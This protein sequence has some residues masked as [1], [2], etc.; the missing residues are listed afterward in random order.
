MED[1]IYLS[2]TPLRMVLINF[3]K[4]KQVLIMLELYKACLPLDHTQKCMVCATISK[5]LSCHVTTFT[6]RQRKFM[7]HNIL[8]LNYEAAKKMQLLYQYEWLV[9]NVVC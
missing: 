4:R 1:E 5:K 7:R 3:V 2:T 8:Q 9:H 6:I